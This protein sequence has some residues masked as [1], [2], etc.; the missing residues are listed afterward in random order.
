MHHKI[1]IIIIIITINF[2]IIIIVII[3]VIIII[4][5]IIIIIPLTI[6]TVNIDFN[7]NIVEN[8]SPSVVNLNDQHTLQQPDRLV[9]DH[10]EQ[11][12]RNKNSGN[13]EVQCHCGKLCKGDRG[14]RASQRFCQISDDSE[15]R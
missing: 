11:M 9:T 8:Q 15:L 12:Q 10:D 14:L 7:I 13:N 5:I 1:I 6:I 3:I 2:I 4:I